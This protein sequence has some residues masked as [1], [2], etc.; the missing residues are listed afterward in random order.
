MNNIHLAVCAL[1]FAQTGLVSQSVF[2][3]MT[4]Q[5]YT[6]FSLREYSLLP[7]YRASTSDRR[8]RLIYY[9]EETNRYF[10]LNFQ[11]YGMD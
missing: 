1:G 2:A 6:F 7:F 5:Q 9:A 10:R 8:N 4:Q 11:A 3:M